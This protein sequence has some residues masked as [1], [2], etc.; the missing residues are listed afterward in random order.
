M[1][2]ENGQWVEA[3]WQR[4]LEQQGRVAHERAT[5]RDLV[6]RT[7]RLE[8]HLRGLQ[9]GPALESWSA[10]WSALVRGV[11]DWEAR[12]ASQREALYVALRWAARD[13]MLRHPS[14]QN[15]P[16]AFM[17]RRRFICQMLHEYLGYYY[18]YGDLAGGGVFVLEAPGRSSTV[19]WCRPWT[20]WATASR[21]T[22]STC[23]RC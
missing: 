23:R 16:V 6:A 5:I 7:E 13:L 14:L 11:D 4:Q 8:A 22:S 20:R 12:P 10:A 2:K 17:K 1:I 19:R 21:T 15:R 9:D 18:D 3:D